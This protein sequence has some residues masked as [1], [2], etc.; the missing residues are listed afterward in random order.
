[1]FT[2]L[3][4][5]CT[6]KKACMVI[7]SKFKSHHLM[8]FSLSW[9]K[10][11]RRPL[12]RQI[13]SSVRAFYYWR[14]TFVEVGSYL[15]ALWSQRR[16]HFFQ[17]CLVIRPTASTSGCDPPTACRWPSR[18]EQ[19]L[20]EFGEP[21][22]VPGPGDACPLWPRPSDDVLSDRA[23]PG[24]HHE[25]GEVWPYHSNHGWR[26]GREQSR[27]TREIIIKTTYFCVVWRI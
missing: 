25:G 2:W 6:Q 14:L 22:G 17:A 4:K 21:T 3:A 15:D 8:S 23:A 9:W 1:M 27:P 18:R 20:S 24:W 7:M 19:A 12:K 16:R 11:L 26:R 13:L 10:I 5:I